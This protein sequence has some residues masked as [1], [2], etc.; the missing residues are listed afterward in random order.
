MKHCVGTGGLFKEE[1]ENQRDEE[2][3]DGKKEDE[4]NRRNLWLAG[5]VDG[6]EIGKESGSKDGGWQR[7]RGVRR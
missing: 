5:W 7:W 6:R 2:G 1:G 3:E 4:R